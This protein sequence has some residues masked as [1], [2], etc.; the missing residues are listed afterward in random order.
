MDAIV[1][2]AGMDSYLLGKHLQYLE[3]KTG[4][5]T[6]SEI[7]DNGAK[8]PFVPSVVDAPNFGFTESVYW[9]RFDLENHHPSVRIWLLESQYALVDEL[10]AHLVYAK[11]RI[12]SF[13][14]GYRV[15]FAQREVK[16]RNVIFNVPLDPG[17]KVRVYLRVKSESSM[18][19]PLVLWSRQGL[20][21]K[22]HEEQYILGLYYGILIAMFC[23]NLLFFISIRDIRYFYY[24]YYLVGWI[25]FQMSLNGLAFEYLWPNSPWWARTATPFF[26]GFCG[27]GIFQ[28]SR[29]FL[30][31]KQ[32]VPKL[33]LVCRIC[34]GTWGVVMVSSLFDY[35]NVIK[36]AALNGL[37]TSIVICA[38]GLLS[39][40]YR[41]RQARYFVVAWI[42]LLLSA[43]LYVL[44]TFG[45]LPTVFI[46]E[47]GLQIG[48]AVEVTL[49]SFALA[50]RMRILKE[51]NERIQHDATEMLEQRVQQRT[52]E[53]DQALQ[54]L[55][56]ASEKLKDISRVDG[57]TGAKNRAYFNEK[58]DLEWRRAA[59][60]GNSIGLLMLDIDYFKDINDTFGHLVGDACLKQ[61]AEA[62]GKSIRRGSDELFRY[63]GEEFAVML[64]EVNLLGTT[65][66]GESIRSAI[67]ALEIV[68][69]D[70]QAI[71]LTI[72]VG[73]AC[74]TPGGNASDALIAAA[75]NALYEAKRGGRNRVCVS[76]PS[77]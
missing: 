63:G 57:L 18:Q 64:P 25:L 74:M 47:Y 75:D 16:H 53:L 69:D 73:A 67:E 58:M 28:F 37:L 56:A 62:I 71:S 21:A 42:V 72:S 17:Q 70:G 35:A 23:Y 46:T 11:D 65:H 51:E 54:S 24:L 44:M 22:D 9:L 49:L 52:L 68:L 36:I 26:L 13:K 19:L 3:D 20:L 6:L 66:L 77:S 32:N 10:E 55:S 33:D 2:G 34:V 27:Y 5:L 38:V 8:L 50:H 41:I 14:S 1:L 76:Q 12:K 7:L 31:L 59:R 29:V 60:G 30:Q 61:V 45:L 48:S 40:K 4:K 39:L 43:T 15:P